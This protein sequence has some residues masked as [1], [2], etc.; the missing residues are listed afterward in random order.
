L[1]FAKLTREGKSKAQAHDLAVEYA[2]NTLANT[3]GVYSSTNAAPIFKQKIL[4]PFLQFKQFPQMIYNLMA[5]NLIKAAKGGTTRERVEAFSSFAYLVGAHTIMT[6]AL[7]GV[8]LESAK[9][10]A[11]VGK[12]LNILPGDWSDVERWQY[13]KAVNLLGK[14]YA[15]WFMHGLSRALGIDAHHRL[16]L[17]SFFTFGLPEGANSDSKS[18]WAWLGQQALG[19]PGGLGADALSA[20]SKIASGDVGGGFEKL[21]PQQIRDI[22]RA[23][24]GGGKDYKYGA[25]ETVARVLGFTPSGEAEH[26]ERKAEARSGVESYNK[27]YRSLV[28][29]WIETDNKADVW[30]R[31]QKWNE[32]KAKDSQIT[33]KQL[34]DAAK[35]KKKAEDEGDTVE[36]IRVNKRTRFIA[37][38]AN[39]IY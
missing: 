39:A 13:D 37:E 3:Q 36:G 7:G 22:Y 34:T 20:V 9:I 4:R 24:N 23:W 25:G 33:L 26:G 35:R 27:E 19:A 11:T 2:R 10:V 18:V 15:D 6:G 30:K 21:A 28:R 5:G 29:K 31:I 32:G 12:G 38:R 8:P 14:D 17:N 1:E 16:G